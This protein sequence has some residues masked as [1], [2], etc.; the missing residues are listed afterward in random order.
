MTA[1]EA[2][3]GAM[4][5]EPVCRLGCTLPET[6]DIARV[7]SCGYER[8][9]HNRT[10]I[11]STRSGPRNCT[12]RVNEMRHDFFTDLIVARADVGADV[13][14][15]PTWRHTAARSEGKRAG[16]RN[17]R[18]RTAPT[19]VHDRYTRPWRDKNDGDAVR[20]TQHERHAGLGGDQRI[21]PLDRPSP[22]ICECSPTGIG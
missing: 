2:C 14:A 17:P 3:L 12:K 22:S 5:E 7:D 19:G 11:E 20:E 16:S 8:R 21:D 4:R 18:Q 9:G 1:C 10:E 6:G 13:R 15:D